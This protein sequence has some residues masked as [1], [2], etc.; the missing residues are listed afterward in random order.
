MEKTK[1]YLANALLELLK[2]KS[3]DN[4]K[5]TEIC[6]KALVHKTTFYNH[7]DDKYEL[8]NYLLLKIHNEISEQSKQDEGIINYY[9]S[10]S[11]YYIRYIKN[12]PELFKSIITNDNNVSLNLFQ[13]LYVKDIEK[14]IDKFSNIPVNYAAHFYVS[15]VLAVISEWFI[16]GMQADEETLLNDIEILAKD[17][18]AL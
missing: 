1:T 3:F 9:L 15:A 14:R 8:L 6:D 10:I 2:I 7:F 13:R 11:K 16:C 17:K 12:N 5:V 4:I 18:K